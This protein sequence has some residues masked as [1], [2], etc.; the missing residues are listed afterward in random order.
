M[1]FTLLICR[2]EQRQHF[3]DYWGA[4]VW[5]DDS[6]R[7]CDVVVSNG[8][9]VETAE[10]ID[11]D[12]YPGCKVIDATGKYLVPGLVDMHVHFREPG[13]SYKETIKDGSAAAA[14]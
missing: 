3:I 1:P 7:L 9:I 8:M 11:A 5:C 10:K 2:D 6:F 14:V 13:Y 4:N 12:K